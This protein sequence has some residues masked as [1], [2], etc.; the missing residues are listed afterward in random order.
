VVFVLA[1]LAVTAW[2]QETHQMGAAVS[3]REDLAKLVESRQQRV[4]SLAKDLAAL[5]SEADALV[6][7]GSGPSLAVQRELERIALVAGTTEVAGEGIAVVLS[8]S[9]LA[10]STQQGKADF[11]IQDVD[12]Q[13]VVNELW[14][15]GAE[16]IAINGQRIVG[17]SAIRS[18]GQAILVNYRVLTS[19]YRVEAIGDSKAMHTRFS[20][21]ELAK[22]FG[23]WSEVYRLGFV[24][25]EARA[26]E[27]PAFQGSLRFRYASPAGG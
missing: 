25:R 17:T 1:F 13:L 9:P 14:N 15:A 5:R 24:V 22:R 3:R 6:A 16:A 23:T 10:A 18:A 8:D 20:S 7:R 4:T 12:L 27:L 2:R 26:L 11:L 21:G 19:P